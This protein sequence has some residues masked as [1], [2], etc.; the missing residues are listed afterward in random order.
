[1]MSTHPDQSIDSGHAENTIWIKLSLTATVMQE[2]PGLYVSHCPA[3]DLYSQGEDSKE[4]E[5]NIIEAT[6]LFVQ[7]CIERDTLT[8]VLKECGFYPI[9]R[10]PRKAKARPPKPV[11]AGAHLREISIPTELPMLAHG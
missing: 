8:E 4:A 3:L 7:S 9:H 6:K 11:S 10:A 1:M 2:K 5:R